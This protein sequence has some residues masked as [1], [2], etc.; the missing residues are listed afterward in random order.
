MPKVKV[1]KT[2]KIQSIF[3]DFSQEFMKSPDNKF[4]MCAAIRFLATNALLLKIIEIR[5]NTKKRWVA[6]LQT[7]NSTHFA[8]VFEEQ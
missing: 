1:T 8:K 7:T 3:Q 4:A 5:P 6:D 2:S